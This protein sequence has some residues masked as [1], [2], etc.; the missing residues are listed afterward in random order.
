MNPSTIL[1]INLA[2]IFG[3]SLSAISVF[4]RLEDHFGSISYLGIALCLKTMVSAT[5]LKTTRERYIA[6]VWAAP[7]PKR[8]Q[9]ESSQGDAKNEGEL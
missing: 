4:L 2:T 1:I 3:S 8:V 6:L 9:C 5:F 7:H